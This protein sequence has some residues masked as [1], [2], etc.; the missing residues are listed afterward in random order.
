MGK[1]L[2]CQSEKGK[3]LGKKPHPPSPHI[4]SS[5]V[6]NPIHSFLPILAVTLLLSKSIQKTGT[7]SWRQ[8][9]G[10]LSHVDGDHG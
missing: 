7:A 2:Y 8:D 4:A 5:W 9:L 10:Q 3:F 1:V 6:R